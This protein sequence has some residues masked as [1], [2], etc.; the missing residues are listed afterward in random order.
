MS[1]ISFTPYIKVINLLEFDVP[2][3]VTVTK[4]DDDK[5][6][7]KYT[8][9]IPSIRMDPR[10]SVAFMGGVVGDR[11]AEYLFSQTFFTLY[12][13]NNLS[14]N[15]PLKY[16]IDEENFEFYY[17]IDLDEVITIPLL[18]RDKRGLIGV[19]LTRFDDQPTLKIKAYPQ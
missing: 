9:S 15:N 17:F 19:T 10:S 8:P 7:W 1:N 4:R 18:Y 11:F 6:W 12:M 3:I 14:L 13:Y 16:Y 5:L 2:I